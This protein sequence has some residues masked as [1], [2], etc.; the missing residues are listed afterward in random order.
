MSIDTLLFMREELCRVV[1]AAV[2]TVAV[3]IFKLA[4]GRLNRSPLTL[5]GLRQVVGFVVSAAADIGPIHVSKA[6]SSARVA[7]LFDSLRGD[8]MTTSRCALQDGVWTQRERS[9]VSP[10]ARDE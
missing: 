6:M 3:T 9:A 4:G 1:R 2:E 10:P 8:F 7:L 5:V